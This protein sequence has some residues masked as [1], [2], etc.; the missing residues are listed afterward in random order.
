LLRF[1]ESDWASA[2]FTKSLYNRLSM[3]FVSRAE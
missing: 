2:L 3:C 1:I